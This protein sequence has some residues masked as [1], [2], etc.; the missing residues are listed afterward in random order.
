MNEFEFVRANFRNWAEFVENLGFTDMISPEDSFATDL[1]NGQAWAG[2]KGSGI[3][4]WIT[5]GG[6][7]YVG[8]AVSVRNRLKQHWKNYRD[9][10]FAAFKPVKIDDLAA[11]EQKM[12]SAVE[13]RFPVLNIAFAKSSTA[14]VPFDRVM[15]AEQIERF[16]NGGATGERNIWQQWP[17]LHRKQARRFA[18]FESDELFS[19]SIEAL[20]IF[21][22]GCIPFPAATEVRFW[23]VT[24]L[25]DSPHVF[26]VNA[27]Q[28]EVFTLWVE[29][30]LL[31]R[32]VAYEPLSEEYNGPYYVSKSFVSVTK[33]SDFRE[34]FTEERM[35]ICRRL[36]IWLMRHTTPLNSGSHCPQIVR[37]AFGDLQPLTSPC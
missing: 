21:I 25:N 20:R 13:A 6:E 4:T 9:M 19:Q 11:E 16:L 15:D 17:L 12:I 32:V 23:S 24:V 18:D 35:A 30:E 10:A 29:D 36:V 7:A 28:Q 22:N 37:A 27:G 5:E 3:Y 8:Q 33:Y 31:V 1:R 2:S 14:L 26:R 34:W